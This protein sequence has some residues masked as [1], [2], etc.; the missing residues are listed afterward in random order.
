MKA[1][2]CFCGAGS[3]LQSN[4]LVYGREYGNGK[5]FL[6]E[7]FPVCRGYVGTHNDGR[8]LGTIVDKETKQLR[9]QVHALI[10][11]LWKSGQYRRGEVYR[12]IADALGKSSYHTGETTADEC[13]EI[14]TTIPVLFGL[15]G[16]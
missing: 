1:P 6:C 3:R 12:K 9:M 5:I 10:D 4:A 11:P 14:L 16:I 2:D 7:R 8:P 15:Q 13:K